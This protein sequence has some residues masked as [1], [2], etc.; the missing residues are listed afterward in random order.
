MGWASS[1][2]RNNIALA[3]LGDTPSVR[4]AFGR[5]VYPSPSNIRRSIVRQASS[6][7]PVVTTASLPDPLPKTIFVVSQAFT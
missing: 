5:R 7:A 1:S 2:D 3:R 4:H 6:A